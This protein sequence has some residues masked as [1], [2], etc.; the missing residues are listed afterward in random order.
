ML[1]Q[2]FWSHH[3]VSAIDEVSPFRVRALKSTGRRLTNTLPLT[4]SC[5]GERTYMYSFWL[6]SPFVALE[7]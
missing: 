6:D 7:F 2:M 3:M 4:R 5:Y 1:F